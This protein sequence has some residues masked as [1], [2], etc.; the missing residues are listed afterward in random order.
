M[1]HTVC[2]CVI[3]MCVLSVCYIYICVLSVCVLYIYVYCLCL[4]ICVFVCEVACPNSICLCYYYYYHHYCICLNV[5]TTKWEIKSLKKRERK[6]KG[7]MHLFPFSFSQSYL[8][9]QGSI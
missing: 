5:Y 1:V 8:D 9:I 7:I 4:R 6:K 2:V 3:Y